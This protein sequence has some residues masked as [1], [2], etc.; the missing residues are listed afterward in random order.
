MREND[1]TEITDPI[2]QKIW[3]GQLDTIVESAKMTQTIQFYKNKLNYHLQTHQ[4]INGTF[5]SLNSSQ[6]LF[7]QKDML[8]STID[9][10]HKF[11]L[12]KTQEIGNLLEKHKDSPRIQIILTT[13]KD[14]LKKILTY[15]KLHKPTFDDLTKQVNALNAEK[16]HP[17]KTADKDNKSKNI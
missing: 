11:Y 4:L 2:E 14:N 13:A 16:I 10:F 12:R 1:Y 6:S 8:S 17:A 5:N 15:E 3:E 9:N 7:M